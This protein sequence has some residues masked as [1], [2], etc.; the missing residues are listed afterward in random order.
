MVG[1]FRH[2]HLK[3][4]ACHGSGLSFYLDR[5]E[6]VAY[7][8]IGK[9]DVISDGGIGDGEI[10]ADGWCA[11]DVGVAELHSVWPLVIV[12]EV[13][14]PLV[15]YIRLGGWHYHKPQS[16]NPLRNVGL[17]VH[18][19]AGHAALSAIKGVF[20]EVLSRA[21]LH[22]SHVSKTESSLSIVA[23][24]VV[25]CSLANLRNHTV[26]QI[27]SSVALSKRGSCLQGCEL[28]GHFP[29][30]CRHVERDDV[31]SCAL[32]AAV[33]SYLEGVI[34]NAV[35][36][37]RI[38]AYVRRRF[39]SCR[40]EVDGCHLESVLKVEFEEFGAIYAKHVHEHFIRVLSFAGV[41]APES[42]YSVYAVFLYQEVMPPV[43]LVSH[44][45]VCHGTIGIRAIERPALT[46]FQLGIC[47]CCL[48]LCC[49][50]PECRSVAY[51]C[52]EACITF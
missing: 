40:I 13:L 22:Q 30:L 24:V 42:A 36:A 20:I 19:S 37:E 2:G 12:A 27:F 18:A 1:Q 15:L 49:L 45:L 41:V 31:E 35:V 34:A 48:P 28:D 50:F 3:G 7:R 26:F 39:V 33:V 43:R 38:V 11:I 52:A 8:A 9:G 16:V 17:H 44:P 21:V 51:G 14:V 46:P 23:A 5:S 4:C 25:V 10:F 6:V 32:R 47:L 29:T